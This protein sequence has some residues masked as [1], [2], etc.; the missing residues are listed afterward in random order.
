ME[1]EQI[2][3]Y[4]AD[5]HTMVREGLAALLADD[6]SF[7]I[8]GQSGDGLTVLE[9]VKRLEPMVAVL[10]VTMPGLNGLDICREIT[11]KAKGTAVLVLSMHDN[12]SFVARA[13][14][15]GALGYL[16]KESATDQLHRAL[17]MVARGEMYL[18][19]GVASSVLARIGKGAE[20]PYDR[21][22]TRE[23]QVLQLIAEGKTN[24]KIAEGL[25]LSVKTVD[26]HRMH[27]MRKLDIHDQTALVKFA[28]ARGIITIDEPRP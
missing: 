16:L 19:P 12:E 24:R 1:Q 7:D 8:V 14:E 17:K 18:D 6:K 25:K 5:D 26:S 22:S 9:E 27:L 4:L 11:R 3:V 20:D 2:T 13:L 23:R 10:D 15:C 28:V 21:L